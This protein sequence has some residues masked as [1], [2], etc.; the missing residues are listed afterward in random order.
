M[1]K[2]RGYPFMAEMRGLTGSSILV[3][4]D[5]AA[6]LGGKPLACN[7]LWS[8]ESDFCIGLMW[9]NLKQWADHLTE[10]YES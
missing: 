2:V 4:R 1:S 9:D 10:M 3:L 7:C 8:L 6:Q 5:T